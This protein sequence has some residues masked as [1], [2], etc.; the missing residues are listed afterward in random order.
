MIPGSNLFIAASRLIQPT[1]IQYYSFANRAVNAA[2]QWVPSY[3]APVTLQ[4]SVQAVPR[5]SY[6][7]LGLDFQNNYVKVFAAANIIDLGRDTSGD[8]F[9]FDGNL[10]QIESENSWFLRD[11]WASCIAI[12]L[13]AFTGK[14]F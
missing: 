11:G 5:N 3:A 2:R 14:E 12:E 4:A 8:R 13:G 10:Y 6:Q 7:K 1:P 9:V